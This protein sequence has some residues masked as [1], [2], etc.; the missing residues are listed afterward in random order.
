MSPPIGHFL[1]VC[2]HVER[3][4]LRAHTAVAM[5]KLLYEVEKEAKDLDAE[6]RLALRQEKSVPRLAQIKAWLEENQGQV[7][8]K[9]PMGE[10]IQYC[11]GNWKAFREYVNDGD[12]A[13]DNNAAENAL[14]PIVLGR[15]NW[16][17]AGS[18]NGGPTGA[19]LASL[20]ATCTR[21]DIDP[22]VYLKDVLTRIADTPVSRLDQFLPDRWKTT[23]AT[24]PP[25][26]HERD[27]P[28]ACEA[29]RAHHTR[30]GLGYGRSASKAGPRNERGQRTLRQKRAT[31]FGPATFNLE[32]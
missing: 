16:L 3:N 28:D 5:I 6:A 8:P 18:D 15:K 4:A 25:P 24:G 22:V 10:A 9:S 27:S 32:G 30:F 11:R 26:R 21:H 7:L 23:R 2:E 17:F 12:L 20:V 19:V 14:R 31:G 1:K 29:P 13:I